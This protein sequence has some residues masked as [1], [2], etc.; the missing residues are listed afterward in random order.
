[1]TIM[2]MTMTVTAKTMMMMIIIII[3]I[4][5]VQILNSTTVYF[6]LWRNNYLTKQ[7][8]THE[9]NHRKVPS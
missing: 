1:M 4:I 3:I 5:I 6:K 8:D 7:K 2:I 9:I